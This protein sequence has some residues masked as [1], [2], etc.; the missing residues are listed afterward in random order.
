MNIKKLIGYLLL[1]LLIIGMTTSMICIFHFLCGFTLG[2]SI[3]FALGIYAE[4]AL[5]ISLVSLIS[6]LIND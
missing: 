1:A 3:L 2:L 4:S 6:Y 5:L